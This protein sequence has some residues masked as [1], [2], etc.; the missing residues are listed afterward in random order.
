[1]SRALDGTPHHLSIHPGGI[2]IALHAITEFV[3]LQ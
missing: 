1:M 2:V 3:P